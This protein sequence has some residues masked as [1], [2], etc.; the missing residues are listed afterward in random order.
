MTLS[1]AAIQSL[2]EPSTKKVWLNLLVI[3]HSSWA[4]PYRFVDNM[5]DIT[6]RGD[7][8]T[9]Y[10]FTI[11]IPPETSDEL[12][13]VEL[14]VDNVALLLIAAIEALQTPPDVTLEIVLAD[15][16]DVVERGPWNFKIRQVTYDLTA[17]KTELTYEALTSEPFPY[18]RFTPTNFAGLFNAVNR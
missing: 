3:S 17:I 5:E 6:S 7:L 4:V 10:G 1:A 11:Q 18:L 8:Y 16:P 9:A 14:V 12:P 13:R 15:T 2:M